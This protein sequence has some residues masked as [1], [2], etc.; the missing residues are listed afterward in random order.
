MLHGLSPGG[1]CESHVGLLGEE[2]LEGKVNQGKIFSKEN[3]DLE[4]IFQFLDMTDYV[5]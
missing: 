2:L 4:N 3:E 5:R 1:C